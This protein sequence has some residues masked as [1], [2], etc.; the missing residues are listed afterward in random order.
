M[1]LDNYS[2]DMPYKMVL[3]EENKYMAKKKDEEP[4]E[5]KEESKKSK[6]GK[7]GKAAAKKSK[8]KEEEKKKTEQEELYDKYQAE[9]REL[10]EKMLWPEPESKIF[11]NTRHKSAS[12]S[13]KPARSG[14][15]HMFGKS[16]ASFI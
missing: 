5:S 8:T 4:D 11:M 10:A 1:L 6:K 3:T 12:T 2:W 16:Q 14:M 13:R 15:K 9:K 7:K